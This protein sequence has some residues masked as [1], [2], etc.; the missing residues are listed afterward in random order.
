[1]FINLSNHPSD[2]WTQEQ[3]DAA[4]QYGEIQDLPFPSIPPEMGEKEVADLADEYIVKVKHLL[5]GQKKKSAVHLAGEST[6]VFVFASKLV[7]AGYRVLTSTTR[8]DTQDLGNGEKISKFHFVRF[9]DFSLK[10]RSWLAR[11]N[12]WNLY[13][14]MNNK[15]RISLWAFIAL[16]LSEFLFVLLGILYP[17]T[18]VG[19]IYL[20]NWALPICF[21]VLLGLFIWFLAQKGKWNGPI[22]MT[23][24]LS[25][26]IAPRKL[27]VTYL[28][29]FVVHIG[30]IT[31]STYDMLKQSDLKAWSFWMAFLGI[32]TLIAFFPDAK[33]KNRSDL[34]KIFVS[35]MSTFSWKRI[36]NQID[37]DKMNIVPLVRMITSAKLQDLQGAKLIIL[38]TSEYLKQ[39][40][41]D[42]I[43]EWKEKDKDNKKDE[44]KS[45]EKESTPINSIGSIKISK[46]QFELEASI[47]AACDDI[48]GSKPTQEQ[49]ENLLRVVIKSFSK[50]IL[51]KDNG[52]DSL[53][54]KELAAIDNLKIEFT[55][56]CNYNNYRNCFETLDRKLDEREQNNDNVQLIF[57]MTPGTVVVSSVM[58]LFSVDPD[59]RLFYHSQDKDVQPIAKMTEINKDRL[60]IL[61]VLS[62][63]IDKMG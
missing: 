61:R 53:D 55:D 35:G 11:M 52:R 1:M 56:P 25:N 6:F 15:D 23:K 54:E 13:I 57:N 40:A 21:F 14:R 28:F 38:L 32:V 3:K 50:Y 45:N 59:R 26:A 36:N 39:D 33:F 29:A 62:K 5:K 4:L 41:V 34:K 12:P 27:G 47:K 51:M 7:K 20:N 48:R 58:T 60:P 17:D 63:T 10:R 2:A 8:R 37:I 22:I 46:I 19:M 42:K 30:W 24:L 43:D 16:V 18:Q 31:N 49:V 44:N 9:R